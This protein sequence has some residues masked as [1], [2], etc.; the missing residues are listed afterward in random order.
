MTPARLTCLIPL[1][2]L[3]GCPYL[4]EDKLTARMDLDGDGVARPADCDDLDP[5]SGLPSTFFVDVDGDGWGSSHQ[6]EACGLEPGLSTQG[7][8]C[9]DGDAEVHP[10]APERCNEL[11]DDCDGTPDDGVDIPSWYLD[12]DGDSYGCDDE[13]RV[14]CEQPPGFADNAEDCDDTDHDINPELL[15][16]ADADGDGYGDPANTTASCLQ[17]SGYLADA[18][19]CDDARDDVHPSAPEICDESDVDEDCDGLAEDED[20][21][22]TGQS[23]WYADSDGDGLGDL[24]SPTLACDQPSGHCADASDCDDEDAH[25]TDQQCRWVDLK[26]G[27]SSNCGLLGDGTVDCWSGIT[28]PAGQFLVIDVGYNCGVGVQ[29]DGGLERWGDCGAVATEP[30]PTGSFVDVAVGAGIDYHACAVGS[31]GSVA[32]WGEDNQGESTP[33]EGSFTAVAVG[34]YFSCALDTA[35]ALQCW[36]RLADAVASDAGPWVRI[37]AARQGLCAMDATGAIE[38]WYYG[39]DGPWSG[40]WADLDCD[41]YACCALDTAGAISCYGSNTGHFTP[42]P[43]GSYEVVATGLY[44]ACAVDSDNAVTCWGSCSYGCPEP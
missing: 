15:W 26:L 7:G 35:G 19:D 2:V 21:D 37:E 23:T 30:M 31:D 29:A 27:K 33:P 44:H 43:E 25:V 16:Y 13:V 5:A 36:G 42:I 24:F 12:S 34:E 4:D 17:P 3:I 14:Q 11:D 39:A 8:D 40:T 1:A 10:D 28:A 38:C 20:P 22:S 41:E 6:Q 18:T 32:C 9:D